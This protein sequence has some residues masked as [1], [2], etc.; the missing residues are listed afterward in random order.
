MKPVFILLIIFVAVAG[1]VFSS[2]AAAVDSFM[3]YSASM[4]KEI[5]CTVIRPDAYKKRKKQRFAVVYLLHGY[6]GW[7]S[8]WLMR[9]PELKQWADD[10][11][12]IIVCPDGG[13]SS[14]YFDSPLDSAMRYETHVAK[15][16]VDYT[17]AHYRTVASAAGRAITG[18]SMGGHGG[19]F[20]GLRHADV[21]GACGSMSGGVDLNA[22][23]LKFDIT[24]RIGDTLTYAQNWKDYTVYHT[25]DKY[26]QTQQAVILDCGTGDFYFEVNR[27][28]HQK[29]LELNIP[30]DYIE[31]PGKHDWDYWR[32]A[33]QYQ[34]LFFKNYFAGK[35]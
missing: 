26:R 11:Q 35:Q 10:H 18:L 28:L 23:R 34:L 31:R 21:F 4:K 15:E 13:Y 24:K 17:D 5:P 33:V 30:H 22:S 29:M 27:R 6:S 25:I 3:I 1:S 9:V 2:K 8:N 12:L 16:V 32:N 14:W 7:H 20:L 19:L